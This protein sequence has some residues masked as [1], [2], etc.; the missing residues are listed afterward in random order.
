MFLKIFMRRPVGL[1]WLLLLTGRLAWAQAPAWQQ[2]VGL[3]DVSDIR[4]TATDAAGNVF[5]AGSFYGSLRL[6]SLNLTGS[7]GNLFVAKWSPSAGFVWA[8]ATNNPTGS[9]RV[10]VRGLAVQGGSVYVTGF[11]YSDPT[12]FGPITVTGQGISCGFLAKLTDA[13]NTGSFTWAQALNGADVLPVAVAVQG[14][15]VYVSGNFNGTLT[16]GASAL[17]NQRPSGSEM[18]VAKLTDAGGSA[19]EGWARRGGGLAQVQGLAVSGNAVYVAGIISGAPTDFGAT[20]LPNTSSGFGTDGF[21]AKLADAGS[22]GSFTWVQG[23][24]GGGYEYV[25]ALAARGNDV[26]LAGA[27]GSPTTTFGSLSLANAQGGIGTTPAPLDAYVAKLRDAG[28]TASF[29][30]ALR[31]GGNDADEVRALALSGPNVLITGYQLSPSADYGST[32]LTSSGLGG[33]FVARVNDAGSSA[34]FAWAQSAATNANFP[35]ECLTVYGPNVYVSGGFR[36]T[37]T[38]GSYTLTTTASPQAGYLASLLDATLLAAVPASPAVPLTAF[39]NPAH[40]TLAVQ[41]PA[42][43]LA[44]CT[45]LDALGRPVRHYPAASGSRQQLDVSG[46]APGLYTLRLTAAAATGTYRVVLY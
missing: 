16:V 26:Y 10:D 13:G 1:L 18:F 11:K 38:F 14:S 5:L 23:I 19:T 9:G 39:P 28:S 17:T 29:A 33:L 22:T 7:G 37:A 6:G 41:L 24:G 31:A 35:A 40:G 8:Q 34:Q 36:G 32:T 44:R 25:R 15:N 43:L 30:W 3:S 42:P 46:L 2:A 4:A 45:L 12:T 27:F 20:T 21:V